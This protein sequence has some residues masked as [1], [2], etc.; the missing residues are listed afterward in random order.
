MPQRSAS[1]AKMSSGG[2][3]PRLTFGTELE[4][5]PLLLVLDRRFPDEVFHVVDTAQ[6]LLHHLGLHVAAGIE[7]ADA[8]PGLPRLHDYFVS[9][10][11]EV[12]RDLLVHGG[13]RNGILGIFLAHLGEHLEARCPW[14]A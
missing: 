12:A 7:N 10:L 11:R 8:M 2:M 6:N 5:K 3:L 4:D 9:S 1:S 14:R 13:S